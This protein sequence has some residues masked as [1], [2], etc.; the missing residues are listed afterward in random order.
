MACG[1]CGG[2]L[3]TGTKTQAVKV[4]V[5]KPTYTGLKAN[6]VKIVQ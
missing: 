3:K 1:T 6:Q 4:Q 5:V 2:K